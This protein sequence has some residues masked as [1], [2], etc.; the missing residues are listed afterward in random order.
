MG[1][2]TAANRALRR[3]AAELDRLK[4]EVGHYKLWEAAAV[5][6]FA[7]LTGWLVSNSET[8]TRLTFG[9]ATGGVILVGIGIVRVSRQI[10][11][12]IERIGKL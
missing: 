1:K 7:T 9:L 8:A 10:D 3:R 2:G 4:E 12:R 11:S 5:A 6:I